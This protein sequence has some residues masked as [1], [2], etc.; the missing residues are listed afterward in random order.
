MPLERVM[1]AG[2]IQGPLLGSCIEAQWKRQADFFEPIQQVALLVG[3]MG[4]P[5]MDL[6]TI[7]TCKI[8]LV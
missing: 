8:R 3:F 2:E 6:R 1:S 5:T 4:V 7:K